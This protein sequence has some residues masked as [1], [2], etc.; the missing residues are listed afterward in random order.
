MTRRRRMTAST[1]NRCHEERL[2]LACARAVK[3]FLRN[4]RT[5]VA[6]EA[7]ATWTADGGGAGASGACHATSSASSSSIRT[8]DGSWEMGTIMRTTDGGATWVCQSSG[9]L[10]DADVT[11]SDIS[12]GRRSGT[13][14]VF[15]ARAT[16]GCTG[17]FGQL[18]DAANPSRVVYKREHRICS[19]RCVGG[20][21]GR[22]TGLLLQTI[23]GGATWTRPAGDSSPILE[24]SFADAGH[25]WLW[26]TVAQSSVQRMAGRAGL[27]RSLILLS[28]LAS[29]V[30][31]SLQRDCR[32]QR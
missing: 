13:W 31:G 8:M 11:S 25:G 18:D 17:E 21:A 22:D 10:T 12:R 24:R 32:G 3:R 2:G 19:R 14:G 27:C 29:G 6:A 16:A 9:T 20:S 5:G 28:D 26:V 30:L 4:R 23:D 1:G 7:T 15:F